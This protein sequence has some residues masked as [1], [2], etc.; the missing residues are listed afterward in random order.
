MAVAAIKA[1]AHDFIEKPFDGEA[2]I[3]RVRDAVRDRTQPVCRLGLSFPGMAELTSREMD[4]ARA[5]RQRLLEQG[6][7]PDPRHFAAH[8]RGASRG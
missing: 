7:R 3:E 5:D 4:D 2:V 1:G 6:S 8:S